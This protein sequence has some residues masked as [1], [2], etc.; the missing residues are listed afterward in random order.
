VETVELAEV[1]QDYPVE[2]AVRVATH[3]CLTKLN[4]QAT[5]IMVTNI[6]KN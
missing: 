3:I 4:F 2:Q 6:V 5:D 1:C